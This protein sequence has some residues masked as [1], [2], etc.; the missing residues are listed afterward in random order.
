MRMYCRCVS[1]VL[2]KVIG[3]NIWELESTG[4]TCGDIVLEE[5]EKKQCWKCRGRK[6]LEMFRGENASCN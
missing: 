1:A 3:E 2:R 6:L 5:V 4:L